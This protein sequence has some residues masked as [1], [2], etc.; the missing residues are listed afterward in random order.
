M[1]F[2]TRLSFSMGAL[3]CIGTAA[4]ASC[5]GQ[6]APY[7]P[8]RPATSDEQRLIFNEFIQV[9]YL[10]RNASKAL[11]SH[12]PEDYIQHNPHALSGRQNTIDVLEPL[13]SSEANNFT[14]LRQAFT[15]NIAFAHIRLDVEGAEPSAVV[16]VYRLNGTC[17][18]EHWDVIQQ[19]D[20][21]SVNPLALF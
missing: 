18:M 21:N 16:D 4:A 19:R 6:T 10:E 12:V 20:P 7:C 14:I 9:F 11:L 13:L 1:R 17:I 8:P 3:A 5:P 2:S 15:D